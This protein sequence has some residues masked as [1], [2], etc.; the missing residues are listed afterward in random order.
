MTGHDQNDIFVLGNQLLPHI[1]T[2]IDAAVGRRR[3]QVSIIQCSSITEQVGMGGD[4]HIVIGVLINN[5]TCPVQNSIL[6]APIQGDQQV[7]HIANLQGSPRVCNVI[8]AVEAAKLCSVGGSTHI[9]GVV[10]HSVVFCIL[11]LAIPAQVMVAANYRVRNTGIQ[12][13]LVLRLGKCP[14][15]IVV[16]I[17]DI[18]QTKHILDVLF[19]LI[20]H[21]PVKQL[22]R[23]RLTVQYIVFHHNLGIGN[24]CKRI[25]I[26]GNSFLFG[27]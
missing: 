14:L 22:S 20:C 13:L 12:Q 16:V 23:I 1:V 4:D 19:F 8:R 21:D 7:L 11:F 27:E 15:G 17:G 5:V 18:T 26:I 3:Y 25:G 10:V 24:D 9:V 6:C 2:V